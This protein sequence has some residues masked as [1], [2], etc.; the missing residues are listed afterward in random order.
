MNKKV[1]SASFLLAVI[2]AGAIY[3]VSKSFTLSALI[4][5]VVADRKSVV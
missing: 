3:Y 4:F 5:F 2:L 1:T